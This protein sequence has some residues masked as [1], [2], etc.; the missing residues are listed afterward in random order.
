L[1]H[2]TPEVSL[3]SNMVDGG[4]GGGAASKEEEAATAAHRAA[5]A[6][7]EQYDEE[8]ADPVARRE[9]GAGGVLR[10]AQTFR[11]ATCSLLPMRVLGG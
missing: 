7:L 2:L 10:T 5:L 1:H 11:C 4:G 8:V 3:A 9:V 6:E